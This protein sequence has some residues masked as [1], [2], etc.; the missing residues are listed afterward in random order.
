MVLY[1]MIC[2]V[3]IRP[4]PSQYSNRSISTKCTVQGVVQCVSIT[5]E[6]V[7]IPCIDK[8]HI[9]EVCLGCIV[10]EP[11]NVLAHVDASNMGIVRQEF[12]QHKVMDVSFKHRWCHR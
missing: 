3:W 12:G 5:Q 6:G 4:W 7:W 2:Y 1:F 8:E 10:N 11:H 9:I